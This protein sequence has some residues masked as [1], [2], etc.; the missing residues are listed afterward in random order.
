[1][2]VTPHDPA[3]TPDESSVARAPVVPLAVAYRCDIAHFEERAIVGVRGDVDLATAPALQREVFATLALPIRGVVV[4]LGYCT[5]IDSSGVAVLVAV[6]NRA[7]E[8]R[9][10]FRLTSVPRQ[11]RVVLELSGLT[12]EF[13]LAAT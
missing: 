6:R 5:F 12:E 1:M 7:V 11:V 2:A 3:V 10:E 9:I 8:R 13:G 4:D